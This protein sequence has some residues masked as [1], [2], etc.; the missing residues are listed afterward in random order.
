MPITHT[1]HRIRAL[2]RLALVTAAVALAGCVSSTVPDLNN[3]SINGFQTNP[4]GAGAGAIAVGMVRGARDNTMN[5]VWNI[6]ALGREGYEMGVA[7][8]DLTIYVDGPINPATFFV[9]VLWN[10]NYSDIRAGN[11]VLDAMSKISDLTDQQKSAMAGF[12]QTMEAFDLIQLAATRDTFGL[13]IAVDVSPSGPPAPIADKAAV[14]QHIFNLLDSAQTSLLAGGDAFSFTLPA[15]FSGFNTPATFLKVN[16][17]LRAR[18]DIL[19]MNWAAALTD[20]SASF[21]SQAQPLTYGPIFEFSANSGDETNFLFKPFYYAANWIHDSAQ[22]QVDGHTLDNR[23]LVKLDSVTPF[24]LDHIAANWQFTMY[25]SVSAPLPMLRN[26]ELLLLKAEAELGSGDVA[27]ATT[28]INFIRA[29]SGNLPPIGNP[30]VP[31]AALR[32]RATLLDELLYEK[33]YSLLWESGSN[34]ISMRLYGKLNE[35]PKQYSAEHIF[36][37]VPFPLNDCTARNSAP[38]GCATVTGF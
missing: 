32:Q 27:D 5:M 16:R 10:Q 11:T 1:G 7:Q 12:I 17:G 20:L 13:P 19:T 36:P 18:A 28:D 14:Y 24:T 33:R 30:Y 6:G 8:G 26:E 15:G 4:T 2:G 25:N 38:S 3:P 23:V 34:W 29:A 31:N 35:I 21:M 22:F 9:D 37:V